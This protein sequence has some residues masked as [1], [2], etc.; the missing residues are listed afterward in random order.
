MS[1]LQA[2]ANPRAVTAAGEWALRVVDRGAGDPTLRTPC[3]E[4]TACLR[5]ILS[6]SGPL[7]RCSCAHRTLRRGGPTP[8]GPD[9]PPGRSEKFGTH[10][11]S[12]GH[13]ARPAREGP[14]RPD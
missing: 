11:V 9:R 3:H 8:R 2:T 14:D 13:A 7:P 1:S 4:G 5:F 6:G 12:V 10:D